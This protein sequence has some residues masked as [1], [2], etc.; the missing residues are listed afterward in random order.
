MRRPYAA[1]I[2]HF[3]GSDAYGS[4]QGLAAVAGADPK[5]CTSLKPT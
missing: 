1:A 2:I 5:N 3:T 4:G